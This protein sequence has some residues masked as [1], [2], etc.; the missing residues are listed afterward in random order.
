M[1]ISYFLWWALQPT[2]NDG[3]PVQMGTDGVW[4]HAPGPV[5][6]AVS[7]S[8]I[9]LRGQARS[10]IKCLINTAAVCAEIVARHNPPPSFSRRKIIRQDPHLNLPRKTDR[11]DVILRRHQGQL[12]SAVPYPTIPCHQSV[13]EYL[14]ASNSV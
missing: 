3:L 7:T 1:D 4:Q 14:Q 10:P 2:T 9:L 13:G 8:T 12:L 5:P 11:L 6:P